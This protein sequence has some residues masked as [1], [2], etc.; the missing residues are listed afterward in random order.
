PL[1]SVL[2]PEGRVEAR[3]AVEHARQIADGPSG[4]HELGIVHRDLKPD[5]VIVAQA[6]NGGDVPKIVDF[7]IAKA[8][9]ET[10]QD[11]LTR[12]GLVIGT[13]EYMSPEQLLGDPIDARTDVYSLGC[14]VYQII[15]GSTAFAYESSG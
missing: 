7:G 13:P 15:T 1:S 9:S 6:R 4:A 14:I 12:S 10:P 11:A 5:N 2:A 8:A 3:R